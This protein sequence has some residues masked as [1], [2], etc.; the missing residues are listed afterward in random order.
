M[1]PM[2]HLAKLWTLQDP[3]GKVH[4]FWNLRGWCRQNEAILPG[5]AQ[6]MERNMTIIK[7]RLHR[8]P[9]KNYGNTY[10]GWTLLDC[11][12]EASK[13]II[14]GH[15]A[16]TAETLS[17]LRQ[18]RGLS[19]KAAAKLCGLEKRRLVAYESG[20]VVPKHNLAKIAAGFG[21]PLDDVIGLIPSSG[22]RDARS[23]AV[24]DRLRELINE[25]GEKQ[26]QLASAVRASSAAVSQWLSGENIPSAARLT[27]IAYHYGVHYDWLAY[28]AGPK[29]REEDDPNLN[30]LISVMSVRSE[31][32]K[33]LI[34]LVVDMPEDRVD[35]LLRR[36]DGRG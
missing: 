2:H 6:Q 18:Q 16:K 5:T 1:Q 20:S 28:G 36:L 23:L 30:L 12:V 34:R 15:P 29:K 22:E 24:K 7:Y 10:C 35:A 27:E 17:R 31:E 26:Y 25:A 33:R 13:A 9:E 32:K 8:W 14:P 21:V 11:D 4:Q 19:L 3:G